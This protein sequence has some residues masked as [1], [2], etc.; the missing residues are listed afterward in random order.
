MHQLTEKGATCISRLKK[1]PH[2]P[3]DGKRSDMHKW[4]EKTTT[5][6]NKN[7]NKKENS[8]EKERYVCECF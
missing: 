1:E 5:K 6:Q 2:A 7:N 8:N 3:E 4:T